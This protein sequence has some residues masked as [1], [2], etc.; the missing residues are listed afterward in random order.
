RFVA[1]GNN[2]GQTFV[3]KQALEEETI[4]K[5][6]DDDAE[7]LHEFKA[8]E[9][10]LPG[11]ERSL[12]STVRKPLAKSGSA[13]DENARSFDVWSDN[14]DYKTS[15]EQILLAEEDAEQA[16]LHAKQAEERQI[17]QK[18]LAEAKLSLQKAQEEKVLADQRRVKAEEQLKITV[19]E[20]IGAEVE[21]HKAEQN[22]ARISAEKQN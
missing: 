4:M 6:G 9:S 13:T 8:N 10:K 22:R 3:A 18:L 12:E 7:Q 21:R 15:R 5:I 16:A 11:I 20:R 14:N 1:A 17:V 2:K 19:L